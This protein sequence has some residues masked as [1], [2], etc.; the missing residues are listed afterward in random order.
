LKVKKE[1]AK[2]GGHPKKAPTTKAPAGAAAA[3]PKKGG[4]AKEEE[5]IKYKFSNEEVEDKFAELVPESQTAELSEKNYKLRLA[6]M[7]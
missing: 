6:G 1:A 7:S 4:K 3:P 5:V 2:P